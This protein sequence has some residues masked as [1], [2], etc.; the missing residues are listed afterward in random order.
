[1]AVRVIKYDPQNTINALAR[2]ALA[3]GD[4]CGLNTAGGAEKAD[5]SAVQGATTTNRAYG[6]AVKA[7]IAG[8]PVALAPFCTLDGFAALTI[9]GLCYLS[10]VAGTPSQT[11][12]STN[13]QT[14][15]VLGMA[16]SAT[17]LDAVVGPPFQFQTAAI[18]TLTQY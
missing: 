9:G 1:M 10:A 5:C 12:T 16:R 11:K 4:L 8:G 2:V 15:Q 7:A 18:S 3:E 6:F 14:H 17:E 13:T